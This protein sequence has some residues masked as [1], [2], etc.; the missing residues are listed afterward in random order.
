MPVDLDSI[1]LADVPGAIARLLARL[2]ARPATVKADDA[3]T[4]AQAAKLLG[5]SRKYVYAHVRELGGV[6]LGKGPKAPIR[7]FRRKLLARLG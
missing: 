7:F 1:P 2:S 3:L 5:M 4:P 6:R